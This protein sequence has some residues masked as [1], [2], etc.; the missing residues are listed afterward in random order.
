MTEAGLPI[1]LK[2]GRRYPLIAPSKA[3]PFLGFHEPPL[4][5]EPPFEESAFL[6]SRD[7]S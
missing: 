2:R 7:E 4:S 3:L 1:P 5:T 6:E